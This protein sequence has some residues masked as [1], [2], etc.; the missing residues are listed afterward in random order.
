MRVVNQA[1]GRVIR[2]I[3]DFGSIFLVDQRY[4]KVEYKSKV[5]RW[6]RHLI[7]DIDFTEESLAK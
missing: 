4:S 7:T 6:A 1:I 2:H 5:S 3:N